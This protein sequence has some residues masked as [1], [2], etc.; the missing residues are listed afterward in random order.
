MFRASAFPRFVI[1]LVLGVGFLA[2]GAPLTAQSDLDALVAKVLT[3]RDD[4]WKKLQQ[5]VLNERETFQLL[6]P[7]SRPMFGFRREYLWFPRAGRFIT[8]PLAADG[9]PIGEE[10]RRREKRSGCSARSAGPR[11]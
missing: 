3:R 11:G 2:A 6:A 5:Y 7:G 8:S 9:V 10:Q 1:A 4:N